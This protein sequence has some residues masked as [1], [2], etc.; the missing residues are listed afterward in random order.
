MVKRL[1]IVVGVLLL[2]LTALTYA[3]DITPLPGD[4]I[5]PDAHIN[6]PPPVYVLRGEV[7]LRGSANLANMTNY[8]IE[9]RPLELNINET[10][11]VPEAQWFPV[12]LPS[13]RP[14]LDDV[15]GTWDTRTTPDGLYALRLTVNAAQRAP[16]FFI[17]SPI[18]VENNPPDFVVI[19]T[20]EPRLLASA[21]PTQQTIIRPTLA[22]T[23]T[24]F[25]LT[26]RVTAVLNANIRAG[27]GVGYD[28]IGTLFQGDVA[29]VVGISS[30]G[31]GW[32]FIEL[33]D[34]TRGWIAPS[35]VRAEG[36]IR[37]VPRVNP[38]ASPTPPATNT[39]I[40]TGNLAGTNPSITPNPPT[41]LVPFQVLA[42]ITN[43]GNARTS[44][45]VTVTIQDVHVNS[46]QVQ[47]TI[48]RTVPE[49]D[50]GANF[51]V[52][53]E[54]TIS[55]FYNEEHRIVVVIDVNN[56]VNESNESDNVLVS[57]YVLQ[58]GACP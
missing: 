11:S 25:D 4:E 30:S 36:D 29:R 51:V 17:V 1:P 37:S 18:R 20:P 52:G 47:Q 45:P 42:N 19:E 48:V 27:D 16:T 53:G 34:G 33:V 8:F 38:P 50:P 32:Y 13:S 3:Q 40:P 41:C 10:D 26:P 55:T 21:T 14:V 58:K 5:N 2:A 24:Q 43:N 23:P 12:T 57:S 15:L 31:N 49:L 28:V 44:R 22:P 56:E 54:F 9:F 6:W 7:D 46:G 39:P 35:T